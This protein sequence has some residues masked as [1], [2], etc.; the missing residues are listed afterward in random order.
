MLVPFLSDVWAARRRF[1]GGTSVDFVSIAQ[2]AANPS[3]DYAPPS[4]IPLDD[5]R[6]S[7]GVTSPQPE[8]VLPDPNLLLKLD[9]SWK[10]LR[11]YIRFNDCSEDFTSVAL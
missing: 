2:I 5:E 4:R 6:A 11:Q 8:I 7:G 10:G 1:I 9:G 3:S